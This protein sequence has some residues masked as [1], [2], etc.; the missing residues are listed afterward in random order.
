MSTK[1][2]SGNSLVGKP[3]DRVDGR[4]KVTG[5]AKYSGDIKLPNMAYAVV[6]QSTISSGK[7]TSIDVTAAERVPGVLTVLT[8]QNAPRLKKSE[9]DVN[10][11][12]ILQ[13]NVVRFAGQNIAVVVADTFEIAAHAADLVKVSYSPT[14]TANTNPD[15]QANG[16]FEQLKR[17]PGV[18]RGD[19]TAGT[20]AAS[21][22]V[23]NTYVTPTETHNPMEPFATVADWEG[24]KLTVYETTQGVFP[25]KKSIA[26]M[27]GIP[28]NNITVITHFLGGGFGCKLSVWSHTIMA[29][30]AAKQVKRP[31]KLVLKR[32]QM[33]GPVGFR[34]RTIQQV[35][36]GATKQGKLT[37]I[38]HFSVNETAVFR[39]FTEYCTEPSNVMYSCP[40]IISGMKLAPVNIGSPTWM[41]APGDAPG[42]FALE[43]AMDELAYA[44]EMD[45]IELR[46][47][48]FADKNPEDG[49][50]WSS[51]SL[52]ECYKIGAQRFGWA[53]RTAA[54]K[55]MKHGKMQVGMGVASTTHPTYRSE[56]GA[57]ASIS[58]DGTATIRS[59]TQD[60]GTGTYTIMAQIA[61][62]VLGLPIEKVK[63]EL[64]E[65][66]FPQTP[67]SGGSQTAASVGSAVSVTAQRLLDAIFDLAIADN[68]SPLFKSDKK[69]LRFHNGVLSKAGS[70]SSERIG[71]LLKRHAMQHLE[72]TGKSTPAKDDKYAKRSFG[73]QFAE[74][75]VESDIGR[76]H[77]TRMLGVYGAGKIL[78]EKT[79]RSQMLGGMIWGMGMALFEETLMDHK[80][81]RIVNNDFAEYHIPVHADVPEIEV[82][83]V[84]E[85]DPHVNP[86]GAK[87]VGELA[88]NG[89][90]AAIANA[91]YHATGKRIR[92]IP[93]TLDQLF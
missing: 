6:V 5:N 20:K 18:S 30:L 86:V 62:D 92:Q 54:I 72:V 65:T 17:S 4:L 53:K 71:D 43:S 49:K 81:G 36:L 41:R 13:D 27:A 84:P 57:I 79:A 59:G 85:E 46:V 29:V 31:V 16:L 26:E 56:A 7:I 61:A 55:S 82:I 87:G 32:T 48:N 58:Q 12:P 19:F 25:S 80:L 50:P 78:N 23:E 2:H 90:A 44:L 69:E 3:I 40:N 39:Q 34:P 88:I 67:M 60:I 47:K 93:I 68:K 22:K 70:K 91:I 33:Y 14:K 73:V 24:D 28:A 1:P 83:F 42:S 64:G 11:V 76:V 21:V 15:P 52:L 9:N 38:K 8:H 37:F 63:V 51:N 66:R 35:G 10:N 74:V 89:A 77:V 75:E 45:P